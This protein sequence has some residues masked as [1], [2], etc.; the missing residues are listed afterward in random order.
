MAVMKGKS[1]GKVY[2]LKSAVR[3]DVKWTE[4]CCSK[5]ATLGNTHSKV[6]RD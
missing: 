6:P 4:R 5:L 2:G 1:D 3:R